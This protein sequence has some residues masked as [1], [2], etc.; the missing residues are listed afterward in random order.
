MTFRTSVLLRLILD[1]DKNGSVGSLGLIPPFLK[2]VADTVALKLS[3][4]FRWLIG[5]GSS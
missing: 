3:K 1:L 2:K 5:L 4:N